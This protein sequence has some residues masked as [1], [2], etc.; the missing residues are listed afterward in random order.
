M[1]EKKPFDSQGQAKK[2]AK[3]FARMRGSSKQ[4]PYFC[5]NCHAWHLT[6]QDPENRK[7]RARPYVRQHRNSHRESLE[8]WQ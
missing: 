8:S 2:A 3:D 6:T 7:K 1:C 5:E 4:R